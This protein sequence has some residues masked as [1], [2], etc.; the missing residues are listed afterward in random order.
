MFGIEP[1]EP[2]SEEE[3]RE[4]ELYVAANLKRCSIDAAWAA[5]A[6]AAVVICIIPFLAGHQLHRYWEIAKYL[7]WVAMALWL[8]LVYKVA[9]IWAA[10]KSAREV[11]REF[12]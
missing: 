4:F 1:W 7:I 10:W 9:L 12:Q 11:R 5:A 8:W 3:I 2:V 6:F